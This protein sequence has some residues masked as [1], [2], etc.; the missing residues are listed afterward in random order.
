MRIF[1]SVLLLAG[2]A[3]AQ[4]SA[5]DLARE[6]LKEL[7]EINTTDSAGDNT[8]AAVAVAK[9]LKA[10]GFPNS[11]VEVVVPAPQKGNVV[12]RLRGSGREKPVLFF[13]HIDVVEARREDWSLDPFTLTEKGGF[14]YGR[15][16]QDMKGSAALLVADFI[17]LKREGYRP[18]R[19]LILALTADEE[20][21]RGPNG[22]RWLLDN[23][24]ALI[25]AEFAINFDS[26]GGQAKSGV[27]QLFA[28]QAAEKGYATFTLRATNAGGHSSLPVPQN[29]IYQ[30]SEALLR[31]RDVKFH[32]HLN[33]VTKLFFERMSVI[34]R[35]QTAADMQAIAA[36]TADAAAEARLS[37]NRYYNALMRTT[38]VPT[39]VSAGHAE[40]ALPQTA[41]ARINC[42]VLPDEPLE[43]VRE[44]LGHAIAGLPIELI[45][46]ERYS[47]N[48]SSPIPPELMAAIER[49]VRAS[50]PGLP[51]V[52]MMETGG[53]DGKALRSAGIPAYGASPIFGDIDDV[54]AH[55]RDERISADC[56]YEGLD[57]AYRL[58]RTLGN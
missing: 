25:D 45:P 52:P 8:R 11:D 57:Y 58:I 17:R 32:I 36:G 20:G 9:R 39:M 56:F 21:G 31:V 19:D 4:Q 40:N 30:L 10:A 14:F 48:P 18:S 47:P 34:E 50:W 43:S 49:V 12:A 13:G 33:P 16:T 7:I 2:T 35:G 53:T 42:R 37:A 41:E 23:R 46:P 27:R 44:A 28:V 15:G 5:R 51:V 24:R 26:G 1:M 38:C 29:A 22:I 55:G 6:C 54:R 3:I